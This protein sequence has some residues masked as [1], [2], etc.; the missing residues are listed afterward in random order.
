MI[1]TWER[2][3]TD[4]SQDTTLVLIS[5]QLISKKMMKQSKWVNSRDNTLVVNS[6]GVPCSMQSPSESIS[7]KY[8]TWRSSVKKQTTI[9][10][11][12]SLSLHLFKKN[13]E[14]LCANLEAKW[15][16]IR[17]NSLR[18]CS[19]VVLDPHQQVPALT[20]SR[21]HNSSSKCKKPPDKDMF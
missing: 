19:A 2:Y 20:V 3:T 10:S 8:L 9:S 21:M 5:D 17:S 14:T 18:K 4:P 11:L 6:K 16:Q 15:I 12:E 13:S 7:I 1:I